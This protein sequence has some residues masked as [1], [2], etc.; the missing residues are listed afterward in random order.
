MSE[1]MIV[2]YEQ[3]DGSVAILVPTEE[4]LSFTTIDHIAQKDVPFNM[5]YWIVDW[6][7]LP[8]DRTFRNAWE[9]DESLGEPDGFGAESYEFDTATINNYKRIVLGIKIEE[10]DHA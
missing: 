1:N 6:S 4:A 5:P 10:E 2:L 8:E 7:V 3:P 9:I